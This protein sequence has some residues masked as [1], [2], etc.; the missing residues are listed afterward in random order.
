M[1]AG[2]LAGPSPVSKTNFAA[3]TEGKA[4]ADGIGDPMGSADAG[5][6]GIGAAGSSLP[7]GVP[8]L[9]N[10]GVPHSGGLVPAQSGEQR[11]E[12]A[13]LLALDLGA[14]GDGTGNHVEI[15]G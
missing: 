8:R 9:P 15:F 6:S 7:D 2:L 14:P 5:L 1:G 4:G 13:P 10:I 3:G 11:I 12:H